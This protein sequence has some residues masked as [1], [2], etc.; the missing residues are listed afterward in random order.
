MK[1]PYT[2]HFYVSQVIKQNITTDK[3]PKSCNYSLKF[4]QKNNLY[5]SSNFL[6]VQKIFN[7]K[8]ITVSNAIFV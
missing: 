1:I 2:L 4:A 7:Y 5:K 3:L 8:P 6:L